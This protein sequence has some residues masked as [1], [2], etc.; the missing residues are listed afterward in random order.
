MLVQKSHRHKS[1]TFSGQDP[2]Y[3]VL[4]YKAIFGLYTKLFGGFNKNIGLILSAVYPIRIHYNIKHI[5]YPYPFQS[6]HIQLFLTAC[7]NGCG[8]IFFF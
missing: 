8:D 5:K 3:R 6:R 7:G 2:V 4:E 1:R